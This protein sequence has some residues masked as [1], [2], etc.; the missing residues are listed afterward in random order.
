MMVA[1]HAHLSILLLLFMLESVGIFSVHDEVAS[2]GNEGHNEDGTTD[3]HDPGKE[4][5]TLI[6][7]V[8]SWEVISVGVITNVSRVVIGDVVN[9]LKLLGWGI[10]R[11][12]NIN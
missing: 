4:G 1:W 7:I 6:I 8:L 3:V 5:G 12:L 9:G 2:T 10:L 11:N